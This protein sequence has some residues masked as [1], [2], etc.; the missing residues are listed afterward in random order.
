NSS[1]FF[2]K[3]SLCILT[4][5][6]SVIGYPPCN[7]KA[8]EEGRVLGEFLIGFKGSSEEAASLVEAAG[9]IVLDRIDAIH[10]LVVKFENLNIQSFA[11]PL[12]ESIFTFIEPNG[13]VK[14]P[15]EFGDIVNASDASAAFTP[16]DTFWSSDPM[17]LKGQW[18]LRVIQ[19]DKAWDIQT[20]TRS[21][22]VAVVDTGVFR[23]HVDLKS[24]YI[25]GGRDWVNNDD[26]PD[27]D[28]GHG[29]AVAGVIAAETNNA[30]GVA[31]LAQVS[32]LAEKA[33]DR[34]GAGTWA[35][36]AKAIVHAADTGA[37]IISMSFGGYTSSAT[38]ES[39]VKYT[40]DKGCLLVA[41]AGNG[42]TDRPFYPAALPN[43]LAVA[44]TYGED[45]QRAPY[46]NFGEYVDISAPGGFDVNLNGRVDIGE[47]WIL[48]TY[49]E[50]DKFV[51]LYG[52]SLAA[53]HVSG[54]AALYK[55][56]YPKATCIQ[57]EEILKRTAEDIG[58]KG[59]DPY[60]GYGRINAY[61]MLTLPPAPL[62]GGK[63]ELLH[64]PEYISESVLCTDYTLFAFFLS[65][66]VTVYVTVGCSG[67]WIHILRKK[68]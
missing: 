46:S 22:M 19:A 40:Y 37:H 67:F 23:D 2:L 29:T 60:Y 18:N 34:T 57:I 55:S 53:P 68:P 35:N 59:W 16:N 3:L 48:S 65:V 36:V 20:G 33:L 32:I 39:A 12:K 24:C 28:H 30:Y 61:A 66:I 50:N 63:A 31:G 9:G 10:V 26:E 51:Y 62:V 42:N 11:E 38:L 13:L 8:L 47:H 52:T 27:D 17:S 43:V 49:R 1:L 44:S 15:V 21:V 54:L 4:I 25:A 45:D 14:I 56:R 58:P 41:A 6:I 64:V 5:T 7:A